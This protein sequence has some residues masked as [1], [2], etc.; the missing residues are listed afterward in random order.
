MRNIIF[1]LISSYLLHLLVLFCEPQYFHQPDVLFPCL[2]ELNVLHECSYRY[3]RS[4]KDN[5]PLIDD[6]QDKLST[7]NAEMGM[8]IK[9]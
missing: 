2:D 3:C 5:I 1:L 8:R 9:V 6:K 4:K 7:N